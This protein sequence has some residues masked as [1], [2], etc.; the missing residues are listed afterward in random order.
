VDNSKQSLRFLRSLHAVLYVM[1]LSLITV[2]CT[3][4]PPQSRE[5]DNASFVIDPKAPRVIETDTL[6]G[7]SI[8]KNRTFHFESCITDVKMRKPVLN[9][10]FAITTDKKIITTTTDA[11]GC[12]NWDEVIAFNYFANA[13]YVT[14]NRTVEAQGIQKGSRTLHFAVNPWDGQAVDLDKNS[15]ENLVS[16]ENAQAA[17]EAL[18]AK[19][20][21][22]IV[23]NDMRVTVS[24]KQTTSNGVTLNIE[25]RGSANVE[26]R[27]A[28]G[29]VSYDTLSEGE[30]KTQIYLIHSVAE[31]TKEVRRELFKSD[32][33][34]VSSVRGQVSARTPVTL[35]PNCVRGQYLVGVKLT[36]FAPPK[37]P[38]SAIIS[39]LK[40]F[41]GVFFLSECDQ[42]KGNFLVTLTNESY[43]KGPQFSIENFIKESPKLEDIVRTS[44]KAEGVPGFQKS[45][46]EFQRM[47]FSDYEYA[48]QD[49][50]N[51]QRVFRAQTCVVSGTDNKMIRA[52]V[53]TIKKTDGSLQTIESDNMGCLNWDETI[54]FNFFNQEC[55]K[56]YSIEISNPSLGIQQTIPLLINPWSSNDKAAEDIR[57][58]PSAKPTC[59]EGKAELRTLGY[60]FTKSIFKYTVDEFLNL[61]VKKTG[62]FNITLSLR[63]PTLTKNTGFTEDDPVPVGNYRMKL[64][65]VSNAAQPGGDL[66]NQV[67][68]VIDKV[69]TVRGQNSIADSLELETIHLKEIGNNNKYWLEITPESPGHNVRLVSFEGTLRLVDNMAEVLFKEVG[70]DGKSIIDQAKVAFNKDRAATDKL[71]SV[72]SSKI[73]TARA[74][75]LTLFNLD[76]SKE[77]GALAP[78]QNGLRNWLKTGTL[79]KD[80]AQSIC[81]HILGKEI[82]YSKNPE[83][84]APF[85]NPKILVRDCRLAIAK[86]PEEYFDI[87]YRYFVKSPRLLSEIN[88]EGFTRPFTITSSFSFSKSSTEG[89]SASL[90]IGMN[91][92]AASLGG[93]YSITKSTQH[94][95]GREYTEGTALNLEKVSLA[96][97]AASAEKCGILKLRSEN[98]QSSFSHLRKAMDPELSEAEVNQRLQRGIIICEGTTTGKPLKFNENYYILNQV[99]PAEAQVVDTSA[100]QNRPLFMAIRGDED[101]SQFISFVHKGGAIPESLQSEFQIKELMNVRQKSL[102]LRGL[103]GSPGQFISPR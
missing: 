71:L 26:S 29:E 74:Q 86:S 70:N 5:G 84:R 101:F 22:S 14:L 49:T 9:H 23:I 28:S 33:M 30:F 36:P 102:F 62:Y 3:L 43:V 58:I 99:M 93:S 66:T 69:V 52:Q 57:K 19:L 45:Q 75:G 24:E 73:A 34:P 8:P 48:N 68:T 81:H 100:T 89:L 103:P 42:I 85:L 12:L 35:P 95:T 83:R 77:V 39:N 13:Q 21:K 94:S 37:S 53:F 47:K 16:A 38:G 44:V 90:G 79:S 1:A 17:L 51:R 6:K 72:R 31:G 78:I 67:Y 82:N 18:N 59:A 2:S 20:R 50:V 56:P 88:T 11:Q 40:P 76:D 4:Q 25:I 87:Q 55:K 98:F 64:A 10:K 63:R 96:I 80:L 91:A 61:L 92:L 32:E 46:F 97:S 41:E 54:T 60:V 15:I 7:F 27:K 65:L